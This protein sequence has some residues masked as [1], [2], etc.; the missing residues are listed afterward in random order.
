MYYRTS[1]VPFLIIALSYLF[2]KTSGSSVQ[3]VKAYIMS[4]FGNIRMYA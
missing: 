4:R 2:V 3:Q 1:R